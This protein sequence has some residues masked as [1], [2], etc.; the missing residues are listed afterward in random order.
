MIVLANGEGDSGVEAARQ[1]LMRGG[2]A[3]DAVEQGIRSVE[4]DTD[5]RTVGRG[6]AP[7][8]LGHV[9]CDAAVM[10][11][12]TLEAG[13]V[14]ALRD[15]LHAISVARQVMEKLPHV[16]LVGDGAARFSAEIG[17]E[18]AD[19]LTEDAN[20]RH[21]RWLERHISEEDSKAWPDA[22]MAGY[23]WDSGKSLASGGTTVFIT[24]DATGHIAA[25]TSTS[26]WAHGYPGRIG[27]TPIIGAGIYADTRYGACCCTHTGEMVLRSGTS[28]AV[29]LYMKK[30]ASV[31]EACREAMED[32]SALRGGYQGPVV[33]HAVD[34]NGNPCVFSSQDLGERI[35]FTFWSDGMEEVVSR[36]PEI[37]DF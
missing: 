14:G 10:D 26:G 21:A 28:H 32:L 22:P 11:G 3:L 6:G 33:I 24:Q 37:I 15:Y 16:M 34:R 30:G 19:M 9:E 27:D 31:E 7:N 36:K 12:T 35:Y 1:V 8:M 13:S 25:G 4:A 2:S 23:A 20:S 29:V 5:I 17:A 18:R